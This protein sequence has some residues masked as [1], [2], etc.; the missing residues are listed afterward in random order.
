[1]KCFSVAGGS[2]RAVS[3]SFF[4]A[5]ALRRLLLG[6]TVTSSLSKGPCGG[7]RTILTAARQGARGGGEGTCVSPQHILQNIKKTSWK[8]IHV[9]H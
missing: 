4:A 9:T 3:S 6:L 5:A 1:M 8:K 2:A 7:R